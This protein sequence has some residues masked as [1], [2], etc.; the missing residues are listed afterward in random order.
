MISQR[1]KISIMSWNIQDSIGDQTNK[2]EVPEFLSVISNNSFICLQETKSQV[3]IEGFISYNSNRK[4][5]RSGGVCI[6]VKNDL[7]KGVSQ[8]FCKESDD[9]VTVKLD[10]HFFRMEFD[11]YLTCFY[12]SPITSSLVKKNPDY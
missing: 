4:N 10:K 12:I 11:I 2:F 7:R 6:L 8:I 1:N 5:S 3:K 9:I